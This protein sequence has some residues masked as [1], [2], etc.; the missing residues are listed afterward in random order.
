LH[1]STA[2][3]E[4]RAL[5]RADISSAR[6]SIRFDSHG[7]DG[8]ATIS[9]V[10]E[11]PEQIE[12]TIR[13][14]GLLRRGQKILVAVSGG[15]DSMVLLH[16]LHALSKKNKWRITVAHLNH[17]L[18]GRSSDADERLVIRAAKG[19]GVPV[20]VSRVDVKKLAQAGKISLE[21]AARK[22]RHEFLAHA[23]AKLKI[24]HIAL[25]HH[26]DDQVELF[27]LRLLRG[28]GSEGLA[29]MKWRGPSPADARIQ[30][31]RPL[32][33]ESKE[34]LHAYAVSQKITFREDASNEWL[35]IQRNLIRRELLPLLRRKYQPAL[36]RTILRV[37]EILRADS[38]MINEAAA[39]WMAQSET[40]GGLKLRSS[41]RRRV[42]GKMTRKV[43]LA[44]GTPAVPGFGELPVAIQRRCIHSQLLGHGIPGDFALVERLRTSPDQRFTIMPQVTVVC[45][46]SGRLRVEES[47]AAKPNCAELRIDLQSG[48]GE[49]LFGGKR[50]SWAVAAQTGIRMGAA[51][52]GRESFDADKVGS[53]ILLRHWRPGDRFQPIGMKQPVKLQDFFTNQKIPREKRHDLIVAVT[54]D[55]EVFWVENLRIS[56]RFKLTPQATRRLAWRWKPGK[57]SG[58]RVSAHHVRLAQ[59]KN[60]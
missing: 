9:G 17:Q 56:E 16:L 18:R 55:N 50:I 31:I 30:L 57:N 51:Q 12:E 44:G 3:T 46:A 41:R 49:V 52:R 58:L 39:K 45:D 6:A 29:G 48:A 10:N 38:E 1:F 14:R 19:M 24:S 26:A 2:R 34:T 21:M 22:A 53:R 8:R 33:E 60:V 11:L 54:A 27:F 32:L 40:G 42:G 5:P 7:W 47:T 23:A 13:V 36:R 15:V 20:V 4:W 28:S 43:R 37:M 35:D 59:L 25:A